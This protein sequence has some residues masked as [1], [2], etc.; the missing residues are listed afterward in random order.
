MQFILETDRLWLREL[1]LDDA[2]A[3]FELDGNPEVVRYTGRAPLSSVEESRQ[4]IAERMLADYARHGFGRWAMLLEN[5]PLAGPAGKEP[6]DA[7]IGVAGLKW[8]PELGEVDVGYGLLPRYWGRGL[9]TE[10][11]RATIDYGFRTLGLSRIIGLVDAPHAASIRVLEK[12]G[13]AFEKVVEYRSQEVL[14][15]ALARSSPAG[16]LAEAA[17]RVT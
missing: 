14:Q 11:A 10:A 12:C 7:L 4:R 16:Q 1:S 6:G 13:L 8:L 15:Y 3:M 9:A 17:P 5:D 2:P